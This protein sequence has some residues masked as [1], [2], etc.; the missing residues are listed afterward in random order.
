MKTRLFR[1]WIKCL[2]VFVW[3]WHGTALSKKLSTFSTI[4]L[5]NLAF[6]NQP[7]AGV[8]ECVR[9][10]C[11][12]SINWMMN[13]HSNEFDVV[14]G[15]GSMLNL[16]TCTTSWVAWWGCRDIKSSHLFETFLIKCLA[17]PVN[18]PVMKW[19][20][21]HHELVVTGNEPRWKKENSRFGNGGWE[22]VGEG[23]IIW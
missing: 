16:C 9:V 23:R 13:V 14:A 19:N 22:A 17:I 12:K 15:G 7:R 8:C 6:V 18:F 3:V 4:S 5:Q 11:V 21:H 1:N 2:C 10:F 20:D